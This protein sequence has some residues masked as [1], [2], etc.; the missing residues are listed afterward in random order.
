[1]TQVHYLAGDPARGG[2]L[3]YPREIV[4][5]DH[6]QMGSLWIEV[7]GDGAL[8][9]TYAI[10]AIRGEDDLS[11]TMTRIPDTRIYLAKVEGLGDFRFTAAD[12]GAARYGGRMKDGPPGDL[13]G[14]GP[15][16]H[17][18]LEIACMLYDLTF[19]GRTLRPE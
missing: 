5:P 1:M 17:E 10:D 18:P 13:V 7:G 2:A 11:V 12:G 8:D 4:D 6:Q 3:V 14:I 15:V 9:E 19:V 16:D